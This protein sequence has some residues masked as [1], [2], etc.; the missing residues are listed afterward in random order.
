[1]AKLINPQDWFSKNFIEGLITF[2]KNR[3]KEILVEQKKLISEL[4]KTWGNLGSGIDSKSIKELTNLRREVDNAKASLK[5]LSAEEKVLAN[6]E[7]TLARETA[8]GS[9]AAREKTIAIQMMARLML[10]QLTWL[11]RF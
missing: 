1:M 2:V 10:G 11:W 7:K 6:L 8:K 4:K 9:K 3:N 5:K